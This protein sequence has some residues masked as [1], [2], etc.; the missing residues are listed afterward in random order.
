[1]TKSKKTKSGIG[2]KI[3]SFPFKLVGKTIYY[4][5]KGIYHGTKWTVNSLIKK[6]DERKIEKIKPKLP[7]SHKPLKEIKKFEGELEKFEKLL[8]TQ[9]KIGIILGGRGTG[10]SA[11][12]MRIIENINAKTKKKIGAWGFD[13]T[14]IPSWIKPINGINEIDN[15]SFVIVDESGIS[16]SSRNSMSEL[17]KILTE[18]LLISRHKNISV[19]F[20]TQNSSNIDVNILRQ[21]DYLLFKPHS[22]LQL[23]FERKIIK[24]IYSEAETEF[25]KIKEIGATYIYSNNFKGFA[26]N[27]LPSFWSENVS[28]SFSNEKI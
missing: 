24:E 14:T 4:T 12:G 17:N 3:I 25:K 8:Q 18:L 28:K 22:L 23:N 21:A 5:G 9:G 10:K 2:W 13:K 15:N 7:P 11:L 20:I 19:I 1:M 6:A 27:E 26:S 16:F